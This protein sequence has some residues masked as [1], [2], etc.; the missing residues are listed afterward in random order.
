MSKQSLFCFFEVLTFVVLAD[1][2]FSVT[3]NTSSV[4]G[5]PLE[6]LRTLSQ[7]LVMLLALSTA[8]YL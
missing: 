4:D 8:L 7:M 6:L 2:G 5:M 1:H 3:Q